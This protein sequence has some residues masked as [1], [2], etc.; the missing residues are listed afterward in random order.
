MSDLFGGLLDNVSAI[1]IRTAA[2]PPI[3]IDRP[4]K[5]KDDQAKGGGLVPKLAPSIEIEFEGGGTQL[6]EPYG[7]TPNT[8]GLY[9][10]GA[11]L[12]LL[13]AIAGIA[14]LARLK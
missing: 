14:W 12:G 1:T 2:S 8:W 6:I 4:F 10:A 11:A 13:G 7:P 5:A 9:A 3:R